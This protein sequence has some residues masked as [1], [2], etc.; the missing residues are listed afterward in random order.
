M[1][2]PKF[3]LRRED[4]RFAFD[5][6]MIPRGMFDDHNNFQL[7]IGDM[8]HLWQGMSKS[9]A[10]RWVG[11]R[12]PEEYWSS[13]TS[14]HGLRM[15]LSSSTTLRVNPHSKAAKT[16]AST[17]RNGYIYGSH[18]AP[19]TACAFYYSLCNEYLPL[20]LISSAIAEA[21]IILPAELAS[22][23]EVRFQ[24]LAAMT[25]ESPYVTSGKYFSRG[26]AGEHM[27]VA[28]I[29]SLDAAEGVFRKALKAWALEHLPETHKGTRAKLAEEIQSGNISATLYGED[30]MY[31]DF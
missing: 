23:L 15:E 28:K 31:G 12:E 14:R 20:P 6:V 8:S 17:V 16:L 1:G 9:T 26:H 5:S 2:N 19:L 4:I 30:T 3:S 21:V 25:S 10:G 11:R 27:V 18:N 22:L 7:S 13:S 29:I 24:A